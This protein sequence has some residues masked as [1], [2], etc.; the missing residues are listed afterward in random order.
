MYSANQ[1]G[2]GEAGLRCIQW[3]RPSTGFTRLGTGCCRRDTG[4]WTDSLGL[5]PLEG[6]VKSSDRAPQLCRSTCS[7]GR[8]GLTGITLEGEGGGGH[9]VQGK[10]KRDAQFCSADFRVDQMQAG[11]SQKNQLIVII[12]HKI[13]K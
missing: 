5:A 8:E 6:R 2:Q 12:K 3:P 7:D 4:R 10:S 9:Y 13:R 11:F 1:R